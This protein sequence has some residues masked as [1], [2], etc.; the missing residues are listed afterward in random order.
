MKIE[1]QN[2][3]KSKLVSFNVMIILKLPKIGNVLVNVVAIVTTR[4]Q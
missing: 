1:V 3:F 4:S 2:M